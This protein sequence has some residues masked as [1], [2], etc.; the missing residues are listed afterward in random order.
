[1]TD[2]GE[3]NPA[4]PDWVEQIRWYRIRALALRLGCSEAEAAEVL[5]EP[6]DTPRFDE[7]RNARA[8]EALD[9]AVR[10]EMGVDTWTRL[11]RK[12]VN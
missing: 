8:D 2:D 11:E 6:V 1:M 7:C 10:E 4:Y 12:Y 5:A 9:K 3:P